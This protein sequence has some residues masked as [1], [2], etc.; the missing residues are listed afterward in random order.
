[1]RYQ[2][3]FPGVIPQPRAGCPRVPHPSAADHARRHGPLDLHALGAPPALFLS[4]DQ[5]LHQEC[6]STEWPMC[7][8]C[9]GTIS[10]P[11][12]HCVRQPH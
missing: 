8:S 12:P 3:R 11:R 9:A 5:T 7:L 10:V 2:P 1:M 4:Q 6:H